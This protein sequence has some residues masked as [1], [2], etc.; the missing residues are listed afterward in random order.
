M[1]AAW[2]RHAMCESAFM[3][4]VQ[5]TGS[6]PSPYTMGNGSL[7]EVQGLG[8]GVDHPHPSNADVKERVELYLYPPS[9]SS[10]PVLV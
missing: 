1:G 8:R 7:R 9:G 10:W 3:G 5:G 6:V 4:R 2:K